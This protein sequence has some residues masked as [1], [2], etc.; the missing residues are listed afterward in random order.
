MACTTTI[1]FLIFNRAKLSARVF[2]KIREAK[3]IRLFM[4]AYG[5]RKSVLGES[6]LCEVTRGVVDAMIDWP[7]EV[8]R[9]YRNK[10]LGCQK[11]VSSAIDWFFSH[12]EEGLI[13]EDD[14]LP[15][16]SF[17]Q[18][19]ET[20]LERYR[21]SQEVMHIS[22]DNFLANWLYSHFAQCFGLFEKSHLGSIKIHPLTVIPIKNE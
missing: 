2:K 17:F 3:P 16:P 8:Y 22:G 9:L 14:T 5:P 19:A 10:N 4:A 13:L 1:L 15:D 7:C 6:D 18:Y 12:V 20:L 21:N 11:A